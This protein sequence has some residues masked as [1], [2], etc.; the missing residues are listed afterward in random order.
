MKRRIGAEVAEDSQKAL[1]NGWRVFRAPKAWDPS[2]AST[3]IPL[4]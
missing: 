1:N 4:R 2:S 3:A